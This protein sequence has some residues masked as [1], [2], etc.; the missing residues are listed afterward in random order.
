MDIGKLLLDIGG[1]NNE[2]VDRGLAVYARDGK[3]V[4]SV[5][6]HGVFAAIHL[7]DDEKAKLREALK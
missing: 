6:D 4:L 1:L 3:T 2:P 7:T 5:G